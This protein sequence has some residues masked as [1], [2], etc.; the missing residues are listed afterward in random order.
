MRAPI[1]SAVL[2]LAVLGSH[3]ETGKIIIAHRGASGY[4]PEHT[5][6]AYALAYGMGAHYIEQDLAL[7]KDGRFICLHDIHLESTTT[8]E[9]VFPER[10]REDGKWYAIDFTL[11][12]IRTLHAEERLPGRFPQGKSSFR[13][14]TF[15]E[16]IELIQGLNTSTGK[17][18][19]IYP[20]LKA[21]GFHAKE[22]QPVE[23]KFLAIL[24]QY[25]YEGPQAKCFVQCFE[26]A[27]LKKMRGELG[28]TLPQVYLMGGDKSTLDELTE[29]GLVEIKAFATGIGPDKNLLERDATIAARAHAAGLVVHPYT[30]RRDQKPG[31]YPTTQDELRRILFEHDVDGLF[32]DFPD[33]GVAVLAAGR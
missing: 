11:D 27:P 14:P 33:D 8:V 5:L 15:E 21:P 18:I 12:E 2:L 19:G 13:V 32:C 30:V 31:K 24:K 23:E 3:A 22:G 17:D 20:E 28:S 16:A 25:G 6:E 7:T 26:S 10:K 29:V 4:V 9:E 1:L